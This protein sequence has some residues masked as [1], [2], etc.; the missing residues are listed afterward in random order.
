M[1]FLFES[2]VVYSNNGYIKDFRS[3]YEKSFIENQSVLSQKYSNGK[4]KKWATKSCGPTSLLMI[5]NHF[6]G[7]FRKSYF[8]NDNTYKNELEHIYSRM[9][10]TV[11]TYTTNSNL[12][13]VANG[14][15]LSGEKLHFSSNSSSTILLNYAMKY[16]KENKPVIVFVKKTAPF[17]GAKG[18]DHALVLFYIS[19]RYVGV[20]D[21]SIGKT[22]WVRRSLFEEHTLMDGEFYQLSSY[23][24]E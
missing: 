5:N 7:T 4:W 8:K 10:K 6:Y 12:V 11:N 9:G 14:N 13:S 1:F 18:Y 19:S 17:S 23:D 2:P 24:K 21:P 15:A 3:N 16:L 20:A 22:Y